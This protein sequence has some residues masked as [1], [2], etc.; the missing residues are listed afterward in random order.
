MDRSIAAGGGFGK[1]AGREF[2][3]N[4]QLDVYSDNPYVRALIQEVA[5]ANAKGSAIVGVTSFLLSPIPGLRTVTRGALTPGASE[6]KTE[7]ALRDNDAAEINYQ[8]P[9]TNYVKVM[10][11]RVVGTTKK[12]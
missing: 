8:L 6:D 11:T 3:Y 5:Q 10:P 2:A 12:M 4:M 7:R 9:I 1:K